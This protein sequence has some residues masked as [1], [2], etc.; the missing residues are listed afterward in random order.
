MDAN[1]KKFETIH[2]F[3]GLVRNLNEQQRPAKSLFGWIDPKGKFVGISLNS[4]PISDWDSY[5]AAP[6]HETDA[7][8][9]LEKMG[10]G[11]TNIDD[12]VYEL[13]KRGW[14][15]V[16]QNSFQV[17][18]LDRN[19]KDIIFMFAKEHNLDA[20]F[21]DETDDDFRVIPKLRGD[22]PEALYESIINEQEGKMVKSNDSFVSYIIQEGDNGKVDV[23][24]TIPIEPDDIIGDIYHID[25]DGNFW[26]T[27]FV[28]SFDS[29]DE[30]VVNFEI[31]E[32]LADEIKQKYDEI[33][34][35]GDAI[36]VGNQHGKWTVDITSREKKLQ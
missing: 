11:L 4:E 32:N 7:A 19:A 14:I 3:G 34:K 26:N 25:E 33:L 21:L 6:Q 12:P 15:R 31:P 20:I 27:F 10:V 22:P 8:A 23:F 29:T 1:D 36:Y 30:V 24:K 13:M 18:K 5:Y 2:Q 16:D 35:T 17:Y 9:R 28:G